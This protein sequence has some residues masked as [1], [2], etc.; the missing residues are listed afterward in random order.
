M[1]AIAVAKTTTR[2]KH[3]SR[4]SEWLLIH[5]DA[6]RRE[7]CKSREPI[8]FP[9]VSCFLDIDHAAN[10]CRDQSVCKTAAKI[11]IPPHLRIKMR[12][13][14]NMR[15]TMKNFHACIAPHRGWWG[16]CLALTLPAHAGE[17][18]FSRCAQQYPSHDGERLKCYDQA[19]IN[20]QNM[21]KPMPHIDPVEADNVP[22]DGAGRSYLTRVWNL[23]NRVVSDE[24][25][26]GRLRPHHQNY[27]IVRKST[28]TNNQP[29]TPTAGHT[30][31]IP[32]DMDALEAK[33]LISFKADIGDQSEIDFMG[34]KTFRLW[35]AYT[36]QSH[37]QVFNTR[38]SSP[39]RETNYEPELIATLG[40]GNENGLKLVN[41]ALEHQSNGQS[42]PKSRSWNRVYVQGGWEFNN[43]T[44]ILAR[45]WWRI[46]EKSAQDDNP[47][48]LDYVGRA[49]MVLRWEPTNKSQAVALLLRNNLRL[50]R[51]RGFVQFDWSTPFSLGNAAR[52]HLQLSSGYGESMIDYNQK[53][54][55]FGLGLSFREW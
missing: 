1:C 6:H 41:I 28:N 53:Q 46:P 48:I 20:M 38:N 4:L 22:S 49:D 13:P 3:K 5:N 50:D 12:I 51:N 19:T 55:T 17:T 24:S 30:V 21:A 26:L 25:K 45:G 33:F 52:L 14:L 9:L 43:S 35:G 32:M 34:F 7:I 16:V 42:L 44:S 54:T 36:Q 37:W 27:L 29:S 18:A 47:D 10:Q 23:D 2:K 31:P 8:K 40:T 11:T 15:T 39:F